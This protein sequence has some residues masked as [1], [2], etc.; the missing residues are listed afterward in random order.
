VI[1]IGTPAGQDKAP[2]RK[3]PKVFQD[4]YGD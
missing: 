1:P 3:A 2:P 4:K